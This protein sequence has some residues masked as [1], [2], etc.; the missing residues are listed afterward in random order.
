LQPELRSNMSYIVVD[1]PIRGTK[2]L[3]R[4]TDGSVNRI[5]RPCQFRIYL[6]GREFGQVGMRPRMIR[7]LMARAVLALSKLVVLNYLRSYL[8]EGCFLIDRVQVIQ[9][10][11][12]DISRSIIER[13]AKV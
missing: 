3:W 5:D 1:E 13:L 10:L 12:C 2:I 8:E 7:N 4:L 11:A 9:Q 6:L